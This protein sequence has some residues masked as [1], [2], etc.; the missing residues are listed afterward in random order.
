MFTL[1]TQEEINIL[2]EGGEI[3]SNI[4]DKVT[5]MIRPGATTGEL[6]EVARQM[7][8]EAGARPAFKDYEI[9]PDGFFPTAL[10]T[11]INEEIVHGPALPSR[12]LQEGDIISID[13]GME[14]PVDIKES[15]SRRSKELKYS[16]KKKDRS[17]PINPHSKLGG[18]YTDMAR[19]IPVG[20]VDKNTKT[21]V[22][23]TRECLEKAIARVKPGNT[24]NDIGKAVQKHAE[25][26]N[27]SVVRELVGHGVGHDVHEEPK[28]FNFE[29]SEYGFE[30]MVLK[31]G[32]VIAIEPMVNVG[33]YKIK[34][35]EDNFTLLTADNSWSAHF[36]D[37]IAI[38][39]KGA[40]IIT[41]K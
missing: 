19:T 1:K 10:C 38:T 13:C 4:M 32:M 11:S 29:I 26:Q 25:A 17:S 21:L 8:K 37:T 40:R 36:E 20:K 14:Y 12:T 23:T 2:K 15:A 34:I 9:F 22:D 33:G 41:K 35:G 27:F 3:L 30:D 31:P 5:E 18:Y 39:E 24:L 6:E 7:M 28:I 16:V